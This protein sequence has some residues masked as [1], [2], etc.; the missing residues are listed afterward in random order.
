MPC[1]DRLLPLLRL[2]RKPRVVNVASMAGRLRQL[3]G[4]AQVAGPAVARSTAAGTVQSRLGSA[5]AAG[6]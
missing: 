6:S 5:A 4:L 1:E 2:A 3:S